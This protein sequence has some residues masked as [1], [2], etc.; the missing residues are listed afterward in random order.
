MFPEFEEGAIHIW[1][2]TM[3]ASKNVV[4]ECLPLLSTAELARASR[5]HSVGLR[6]ASVLRTGAVRLILSGYLGV[7]PRSLEFKYGPAGKP[8][9]DANVDLN[10]N[11]SHSGDRALVAVSLGC[12]MGVDVEQVRTITDLPDLLGQVC[13]PEEAEEI[14]NTPGELQELRFLQCWTRKEA[15]LKAAGCGISVPMSSFV[16]RAGLVDLPPLDRIE[17]CEGRSRAWVIADLEVGA[18][19]V[20]AVACSESA[21]PITRLPI[22]S[23]RDLLNSTLGSESTLPV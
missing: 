9:I 21:R 15:L 14:L 6:E 20:A 2:I 4:G 1:S 13:R 11:M 23:V 16:V 8:E 7:P 19:Y 17:T 3:R 10:F 22:S 12:Q 18:D 5:F